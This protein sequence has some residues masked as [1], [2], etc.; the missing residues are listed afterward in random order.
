MVY[1][2]LGLASVVP[3]RTASSPP[4][5]DQ[6]PGSLQLYINRLL[7]PVNMWLWQ[8]QELRCIATRAQTTIARKAMWGDNMLSKAASPMLRGEQSTMSTMIAEL[9]KHSHVLLAHVKKQIQGPH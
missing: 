7:L 9:T 5:P 2:C 4:L 3:R 6:I 1:L 8:Q